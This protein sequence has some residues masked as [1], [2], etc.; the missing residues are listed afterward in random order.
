MEDL[1]SRAAR[2]RLLMLDVDGVLTDGRLY[3]G[4]SGEEL[5][6]FHSR[7]GHGLKML[8]ESGV[9]LAIITGRSSR[10]L[11]RRA[12]ELGIARLYQGVEDKAAV[13]EELLAEL[14]IDRA[15]AAGMGDDVVDLP[16]ML[17]CGLALTVPDAPEIVRQHAHYVT[18]NPAGAGAVRE[19]CEL[20]MSAQGS[21]QKRL[22]RYLGDRQ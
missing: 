17:S 14:G 13:M 18:R 12:A 8:R 6:V 11:E 16:L 10:A 5:K 15:A 4:P 22:A 20:I 3:F 19:A 7:D 9:V 1:S 2:T 21:L